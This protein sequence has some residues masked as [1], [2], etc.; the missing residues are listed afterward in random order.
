M[1]TSETTWDP[2]A[3]RGRCRKSVETCERFFAQRYAGKRPTTANEMAF[4]DLCLA[5]F[6]VRKHLLAV[7]CFSSREAL[8]AE[9]KRLLVEPV[10]PSSLPPCRADQYLDCQ[11]KDIEF[12]IEN[13]TLE[14]KPH[15]KPW[16]QKLFGRDET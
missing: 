6:E 7:D 14:Q 9:L 2:D 15:E 11:K 5:E 4:Y 10:I 16:F 12:E 3:A 8:L 13:L 1:P